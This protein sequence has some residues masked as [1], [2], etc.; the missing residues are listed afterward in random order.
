[1]TAAIHKF[2]PPAERIYCADRDIKCFQEKV[3]HPTYKMA[4]CSE[5]FVNMRGFALGGT[6]EYKVR[7]K[8]LLNLVRVKFSAY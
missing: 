6:C 7:I 5:D 3:K 1:M 2:S 8:G 4:E